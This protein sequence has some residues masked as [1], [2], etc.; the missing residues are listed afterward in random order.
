MIS[1][2]L[3]LKEKVYF[4]YP[5]QGVLVG[6]IREIMKDS[7]RVTYKHNDIKES[8]I[9]PNERLSLCRNDLK[10]EWRWNPEYQKIPK[11][12]ADAFTNI[13]STEDVIKFLYNNLKKDAKE[14]ARKL[15]KNVYHWDI[16]D[17]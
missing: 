4:I 12:Y 8:T 2:P 5:T 10:E 17:L 7:V 1:R 14:T 3:H 11:K 16:E 13:Y 6:Q 9:V 15:I